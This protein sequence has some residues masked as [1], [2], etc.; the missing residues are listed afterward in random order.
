MLLKWLNAREATEVG[1]A[2]ADAF[3]LQSA[4][5]LS[6][7]R[8]Q[9][10]SSG[11]QGQELQKFLH[12]FL[13]KV[14]RDARPLKLN[15][16]QRAKLANSFKWRL[17]EKGV[18]PEI[19]DELTQALLVRLSANKA[20]STSPDRPVPRSANRPSPKN[21]QTELRRGDEYMARGAYA[22]AMSCYKDSVSL[23]P[24]NAVARNNL[25]TALCKLGHY[26]EAED[27]FRR[28]IGIKAGYPDAHGNLGAVLQWRGRY[29]ESE[30]PLRRALKLKSTH[31][32]A[33]IT[34]G[35]TL[36]LLGRMRDAKACFEKVLRVSP[37][38]VHALVG[39]G[40]IAALEGRLTE[41]ETLYKRAL[42][43]DPKTTMAWAGLAGL[44]RMT[45]SD[46]AWLKGAEEIAASGLAPVEEV[47]MR[48]AI[49]NYYNDV[50][51]FGR[52]FRS[53][54]RANDMQKT[55][56]ELYDRDAHTRFVDDM[57]RTWT[58]DTLSRAHP[59][60]SDSERP[61]FV[62]G[63]MRSGTS[64]VEQIIASHP[65]AKGAGELDFWTAAVRKHETAIRHEPPGEL[66]TRKLAA[67]CLGVLAERFPDALRV[68]D[69]AT[70]NSDYLGVIHWVF[71]NARM[72]NLQRDP[73]DTC[74]S[75]YFQQF[76][77]T[78][79]F[80]LDLSD[81]AHYYREHQRLMAHWRSTLP[82]GTLLDVPYA[83]LIADQERW[84]RKIVEFL[85]LQWDERCLDFHKTERTVLSASYW[86]VRQQIYKSSV[87]RWRNYEKFIGPL[88]SLRDLNA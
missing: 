75:C 58:R 2:L 29:T 56:A 66:L 45:S 60:V 54:R 25:G 62:V 74:L 69:K 82:S 72:I 34:L 15:L 86:Q 16:F 48:Y 63:M 51:D 47:N 85:G 26:Q 50:G 88:L 22:E 55:F 13:Q 52:A 53:Y 73:I 3:V 12:N 70:V 5:G 79:N 78:L 83:E 71:P 21:A 59:G 19:I 30:M 20:S 41:A 17:L 46:S 7:A 35:T 40:Q 64:L 6:A 28:A 76:S 77:P 33:Q 9:E 37:R 10:T 42:E 84:T 68:V 49:G 87:G 27:Q 57:T 43:V 44:H 11:A 23:D 38:N 31:H 81:L 67:A 24:R 65:A 36:T 80:S 18:E 61:V 8:R 4:I 1:T 39:M 14:D 32:D